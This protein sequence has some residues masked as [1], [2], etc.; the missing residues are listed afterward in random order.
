M[1]EHIL[2]L[3]LVLGGLA[4]LLNPITSS[5]HS[6]IILG[7]GLGVYGLREDAKK[8]YKDIKDKRKKIKAP[9]D[10]PLENF[11]VLNFFN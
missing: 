11:N 1:K 5:K 6:P 2:I 4:Q 3:L 9:P 7:A 10:N 8:R